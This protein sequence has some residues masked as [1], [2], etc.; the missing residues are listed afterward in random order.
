M[1][2][3]DKSYPKLDSASRAVLSRALSG[4]TGD[5][6]CFKP[7][8]WFLFFGVVVPLAALACESQVHICA[9]HFFDPLPSTLHIFLFA[10]IPLSN[11]LI[12]LSG[13]HD[14]TPFYAPITLIAGMAMGIAFMYSIMFLPVLPVA[15]VWTLAAG[16]GLLG[17]S[18]CLSLLCLWRAGGPLSATVKSAGTFFDPHQVKHL[19]HLVVLLTVLVVEL[20]STVTRIY[21]QMAASPQTQAEGIAALRKFGSEEVML[22]ACYE[23][24]GRATD[25]LGSLCEF[26]HPLKV[27]EAR[28][29]FYRVTG[30]PYNSVPIPASA[31]ATIVHAGLNTFGDLNRGVEDEF[32]LDTD[33]AGEMVSG[34]AR[35][36]SQTGSS[37]SGAIYAGAHTANLVWEIT[38]HNSSRL[39]REARTKVRVPAGAVVT[40]AAIVING[41]EQV[42]EIQLRSQARA[43]Y[44]AATHTRSAPLLVSQCGP[45]TLLVQC[46]P[47]P[48]GGSL[49]VK[50][51]MSAP[52]LSAYDGQWVLATPA[53]EERNFQLDC[54][55]N[56]QL[57]SPTAFCLGH[58]KAKPKTESNYSLDLNLPDSACQSGGNILY[59]AEPGKDKPSWCGDKDVKGR[60][61]LSQVI[62]SDPDRP[63]RLS[64]LLDGSASMA[65]YINEVKEALRR[66][67]SDLPC[68]LKFISDKTEEIWPS[69]SLPAQSTIMDR[70]NLLDGKRCAG[71]QD[72]YGELA[73][74][75][76]NA[77]SVSDAAVLWIHGPQ[78]QPARA[79]RS[80]LGAGKANRTLL[81][82]LQVTSGPNQ[83]FDNL[84]NTV[85]VKRIAQVGNVRQDL[86]YL[87]DGWVGRIKPKVVA[88]SQVDQASAAADAG[89][90]KI[91]AG[92]D[93]LPVLWAY[94]QI[95]K[96]A[97]Q[98]NPDST[99][100]A[101]SLAS[102]FHLISPVSS[103]VV[104]RLEPRLA[105]A[106]ADAAETNR[107]RRRELAWT[108]RTASHALKQAF[109][110][111][112]NQLEQL[113]PKRQMGLY[114]NGA[115][116][117]LNELS[118]QGPYYDKSA[119]E[120]QPLGGGQ[121]LARIGPSVAS[122]APA[123]ASASKAVSTGAAGEFKAGS[124]FA[125]EQLQED[126]SESNSRTPSQE[127]ASESDL[128]G[129]T[130]AAAVPEADT[131]LFWAAAAFALIIF[132][133]KVR[134]RVR[135]V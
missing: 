7:G 105:Q 21:L 5:S 14:L 37:L 33:I 125:G 12:W 17:L 40:R 118:S 58:N 4:R 47:V 45:D 97:R 115:I 72:D 74:G 67:P 126:A 122:P 84:Q 133:V 100:R 78:P 11:F 31:R 111:I 132:V 117:H 124:R 69:G 30:K 10:I 80:Y 113:N 135:K 73:R 25:I 36:L 102:Q 70:L 89:A 32:D 128:L 2:R 34:F 59:I 49:K 130:A 42:A 109:S 134:P 120:A 94:E 108:R 116:D 54:Q 23:R 6:V 9:R 46:Y 41:R 26:S 64:I 79:L 1:P 95:G 81:W 52:L 43:F 24:S 77:A 57:S 98:G 15:L 66:L 96:Y 75:L 51:N 29:I 76:S 127:E 83:A 28:N 101:L 104:M 92:A 50:L 131:W 88:I 86:E 121:M 53:L 107:L 112:T 44:R 119:K 63:G 61:Y 35:G 103:A 110:S 56:I 55:H 91:L 48:P 13:R 3:K 68:E 65:P 38:F 8:N 129:D 106:V 93:S 82:D 71:G 123:P 90:S 27:E 20:P 39:E 99:A 18:P 114:S 60:A 19:G 85:A 87:F 22:R 16:F 62:E